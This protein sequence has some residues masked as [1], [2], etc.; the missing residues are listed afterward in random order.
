MKRALKSGPHRRHPT[1]C[2]RSS[3]TSQSGFNN[4]GGSIRLADVV[5]L[6][7]AS[8]ITPKRAG[9]EKRYRLLETLRENGMT[10]PS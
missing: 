1:P 8:L 6:A 9:V 4:R 2:R 3:S 10:S 5:A 7:R